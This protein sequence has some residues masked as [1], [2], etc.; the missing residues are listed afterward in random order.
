MP[1]PPTEVAAARAGGV[2]GVGVD[3]VAVAEVQGALEAYG[4][5]YLARCYT[6]AELRASSAPEGISAERL[7][8]C[9]AAKEA[10]LKAL[11]PAEGDGPVPDFRAIEVNARRSG[12]CVLD[13]GGAA[14]QLAAR[15][16]ISVMACSVARS[17]GYAVAVVIAS[18][19]ERWPSW[20]KERDGAPRT[21]RSGA[22]RA[23]A[24]P[25]LGGTRERAQGAS[26][27]RSGPTHERKQ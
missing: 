2:L 17:G 4:E 12:A 7:A 21:R 8:A 3:L 6:P 25:G 24:G 9:F 14:A 26:G 15:R 27:P 19:G 1:P 10:A 5:R 18:G 16:R 20:G 23:L 22:R 13:L 11:G